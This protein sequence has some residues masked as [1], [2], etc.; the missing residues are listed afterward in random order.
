MKGNQ[1]I[2]MVILG[3]VLASGCGGGEQNSRTSGAPSA[4]AAPAGRAQTPAADT[5]ITLTTQPNPPAPG[6]TV[7]E[8][9]V[10][11]GGQP[12]TDATVSVELFLPP[13]P[14]MNMEAMRNTVPLTHEG[15]GRYRGTGD[16]MVAGTWEATVSATRAGQALSARKVS[17]VAK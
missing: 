6:D 15:G 1:A 2:G 4:T 9:T 12:V 14:D 17:F 8:A 5:E 7:F 10:M 11:A 13:M 3:A 16:V